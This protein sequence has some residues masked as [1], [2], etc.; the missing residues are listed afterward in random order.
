M[1]IYQ[2][3]RQNVS[4]WQISKKELLAWADEV[5]KPTAELAWDDKGEFSCGP[6]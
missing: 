6:W 3:R 5:L 4:E 1:S 2:P